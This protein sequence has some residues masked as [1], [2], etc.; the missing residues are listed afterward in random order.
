MT[1]I[2]VP[3]PRVTREQ[4]AERL[5]DFGVSPGVYSLYG[6]GR[7]AEGHCMD[8]LPLGRW[9][10]YFAEPGSASRSASSMIRATLV[11]LASEARVGAPGERLTHETTAR[12]SSGEC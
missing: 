7:Q 4:L 10:V 2:R 12:L 3:K 5:S 11:A 9:V 8:Q 6:T 1:K